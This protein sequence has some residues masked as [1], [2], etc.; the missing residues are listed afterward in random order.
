M[1]VLV[2]GGTGFIGPHVVRRLVAEGHEVSVFHRGHTTSDLPDAVGQARGEY[3]DLP[4]H[5]I[6]F[7]RLAP[8]VV[9]DMIAATER[10]ARAG[11][12]VFRG[13][14]SRVVALSSMDVYRAYD[15]I[16]RVDQGPLQPVPIREDAELRRTLFP[17]RD[18]PNRPPDRPSDYE[19]ILVERVYMGEPQLPATILRLPMVYGPGDR[20]RHRALPYVKRMEDGRHAILLEESFAGW[21]GTRGYVEN[22]AVAIAAAVLNERAARRIYNV[23]EALA[24]TEKE[25]V[26]SLG[27]AAGWHGDVVVLPDERVPQTIR[28][29]GNAAQHWV[30]DTSRISEELGYEEPVTFNEALRRTVAWERSHIPGELPAGML[31]YETEDIVLEGLR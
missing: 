9:L 30:L 23:G 24:L 13:I 2:I 16:N 10:D 19:K 26:T 29:Q 27:E 14:A 7:R 3:R 25:W 22:V 11:V 5:A 21:R 15:V 20:R 12:E 17:V 28:F 31:D 6:E 8:D 18:M 1:R 4:S